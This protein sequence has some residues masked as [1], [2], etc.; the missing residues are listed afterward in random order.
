MPSLFLFVDSSSTAN[1]TGSSCNICIPLLQKSVNPFSHF[2]LTS[3]LF[4]LSLVDQMNHLS[5]ALFP[6]C[7]FKFNRRCKYLFCAV[8]LIYICTKVSTFSSSK[9]TFCQ[10]Q[11]SYCPSVKRRQL[12]SLT[13]RYLFSFSCSLLCIFFSFKFSSFNAPKIFSEISTP[14]FYYSS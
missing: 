14:E 5:L 8:F 2:A 4:F 12:F 6:I 7:R 13:Q 1:A 11:Y 10:L 3:S 9:D